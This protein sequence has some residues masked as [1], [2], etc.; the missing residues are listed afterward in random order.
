MAQASNLANLGQGYASN[1]GNIYGQMS[2]NRAGYTQGMINA[3]QMSPFNQFL[4]QLPG[5]AMQGLGYALAGPVGG[6]VAGGMSRG[7]TP[8]NQGLMIG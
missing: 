1:M 2:Q 7:F 4:T 5:L 6:A 3:Q 8:Q